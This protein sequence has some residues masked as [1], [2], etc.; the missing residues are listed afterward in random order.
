MKEVQSC[1]QD[2]VV[3][4]ENINFDH[5]FLLS[6]TIYFQFHCIFFII[7]NCFDFRMIADYCYIFNRMLE[8]HGSITEGIDSYG[9]KKSDL[10]EEEF[11]RSFS[12]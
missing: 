10:F 4:N 6:E 8:H 7:S 11:I 9:F 5:L 12:I 3:L 1:K 2:R